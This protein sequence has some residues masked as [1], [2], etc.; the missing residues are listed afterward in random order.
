MNAIAMFLQMIV[1]LPGPVLYPLAS[2]SVYA[3]HKIVATCTCGFAG[4]QGLRKT[5]SLAPSTSDAASVASSHMLQ[6]DRHTSCKHVDS[7]Q[8]GSACP[9]QQQ[10]QQAGGA[11][12]S[13]P[14]HAVL[15]HAVLGR[16]TS[17]DLVQAVEPRKLLKKKRKKK[18]KRRSRLSQLGGMTD[19]EKSRWMLEHCKVA[20]VAF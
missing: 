2:C 20:C 6:T 17:S 10:Q 5:G 1:L 13:V 9:Q 15:E 8:Q 7:M 3:V 4:A 18:V 19:V 14:E 12:P 11:L 16:S